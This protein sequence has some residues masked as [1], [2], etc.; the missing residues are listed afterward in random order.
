MLLQYHQ[1][2]QRS[3]VHRGQPCTCGG[4]NTTVTM[5]AVLPVPKRV[6]LVESGFGG[7]VAAAFAAGAAGSSPGAA[8]SDAACLVASFLPSAAMLS[9]AAAAAKGGRGAAALHI[10][11][12][13][14]PR[15]RR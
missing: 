8:A 2:Q 4:C 15:N 13:N 12:P 6:A 5:L 7:A 9:A 3:L 14:A 10:K 11:R 1:H